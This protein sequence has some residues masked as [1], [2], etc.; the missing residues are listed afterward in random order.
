MRE[1]TEMDDE[2]LEDYIEQ[3]DAEETGE[4]HTSQYLLVV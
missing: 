3:V 2:E 1:P 4:L